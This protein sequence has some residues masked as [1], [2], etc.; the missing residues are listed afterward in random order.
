[1]NECQLQRHGRAQGKRRDI[2]DKIN[3]QIIQPLIDAK[4]RLARS[5]FPDFNDPNKLR[6][7]DAMVRIVFRSPLDLSVMQMIC[8]GPEVGAGIE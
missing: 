3:T 2:G 1:M 8:W 6:E 5:D 4:A 7:G